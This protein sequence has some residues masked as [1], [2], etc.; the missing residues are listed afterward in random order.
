MKEMNVRIVQHNLR[1][2]SQY[3]Q[4]I[5]T[6]RPDPARGVSS[7]QG[8]VLVV[9]LAPPGRVAEWLCSGLQIRVRRFNSD[10]GLQLSKPRS[11]GF[12][13]V[14]GPLVVVATPVVEVGRAN[15]SAMRHWRKLSRRDS[16]PGWR[17]R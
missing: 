11:R 3:Y 1:V 15:Y 17:N 6:V 7:F 5:G 16:R 8:H 9:F 4:R 14:L 10:L 13:L 2:V 12:V